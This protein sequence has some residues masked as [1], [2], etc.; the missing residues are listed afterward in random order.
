MSLHVPVN[1]QRLEL[2]VSPPNDPQ[3]NPN[4]NSSPQPPSPTMAMLEE[5]EASAA[6]HSLGESPRNIAMDTTTKGEHTGACIAPAGGDRSA[7]SGNGIRTRTKEEECTSLP[8]SVTS[9]Q[10]QQPIHDKGPAGT[11]CA[12][13][14]YTENNDTGPADS[15]AIL[16]IDTSDPMTIE[17]SSH[18]SLTGADEQCC[19]TE[20][21]LSATIQQPIHMGGSIAAGKS[22]N[23][24]DGDSNGTGAGDPKV[25]TIRE[26][27]VGLADAA[28]KP[29]PINSSSSSDQRCKL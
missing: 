5:A 2:I 20:A 15:V 27:N 10:Q 12:N 4:P 16:E 24:A 8:L 18:S 9:L 25:D 3:S 22:N 17:S 29:M 28:C 7:S 23:T 26:P 11:T 1:Q 6:R 19:S 21:V 13:E 14:E